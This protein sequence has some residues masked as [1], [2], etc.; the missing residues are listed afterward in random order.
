[1]MVVRPDEMAALRAAAIDDPDVPDAIKRFLVAGA[2]L[3]EI[4][5]DA[6]GRWT[7]EG[8]RFENEKLAAL[9][10]RSLEQTPAGTWLLRIAPYTYPVIVEKTGFFVLQVDV[11]AAG[12]WIARLSDGTTEAI[13]LSSLRTDGDTVITSRV[14]GGRHDARWIGRAWHWAAQHLDHDGMDWLLR[15]GDEAIGLQTL[16][17]D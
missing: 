5:L 11:R 13:D 3:E 2:A 14:H 7:H 17:A 9:F 15:V 6:M 10:G 12:E 4:R 1:M 8:G 16:A